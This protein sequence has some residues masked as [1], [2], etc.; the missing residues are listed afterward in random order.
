MNIL[1]CGGEDIDFLQGTSPLVN[2]NAGRFRSSFSR[3]DLTCT[4]GQTLKSNV[5]PGGALTSFWFSTWLIV[6]GAGGTSKR[7]IGMVQSSTSAKGLWLG[8]SGANSSRLA[9]ISFD[10][11]TQTELA[12]ETGAS[13]PGGTLT[14]LDMQLINYGGS[15][16]VNIYVGGVL[17]INYS[18]S[19]SISGV[20]G[21]DQI[22]IFGDATFGQGFSEFIVADS[23]T[24]S[25]NLMTLAL[26]GAGTTNAWA[27][28]TFSNINGI[29]F[30]DT[31]PTNSN[32]AAQDDQY[33][34]TDLATGL[35]SV[36]AVKQTI[37]AATS[38]TPTA[39]QIKMGYNSGGSIAFGTGSTKTPT[40]SA[41]GQF[42]Q[43]DQINPVTSA[44]WVQSDMNAL[45][46]DYR[47]A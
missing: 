41:Y 47:S 4:S 29:S 32:T 7:W 20:T 40:V 28:P 38:S 34:V 23:D 36:L 24:R 6:T 18:G 35:W 14:K 46:L 39:T 17:V 33:N 13:V 10:G 31:N 44:A 42:E 45:Q 1:W 22:A 30:S 8:T 2:T 5:F 9:L 15:S 19:T 27:N 3:C 16:T 37:R 25:L 12:A 21:F 43:I 11:T 26:T